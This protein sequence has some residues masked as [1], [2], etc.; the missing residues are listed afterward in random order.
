MALACLSALEVNIEHNK[1]IYR[2]YCNLLRKL[3]G[4]RLIEYRDEETPSYKTIVVEVTDKW[5]LSRQVTLKLL[6]AEG[7][8]ATPYYGPALH[9]KAPCYQTRL[10]DAPITNC[11]AERLMLFPSGARVTIEDVKV[12]ISLLEDINCRSDEILRRIG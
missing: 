5:P 3:P 8:L 1:R 11:L 10:D 9:Q 12:V 7:V 6:N 2:S 4:L